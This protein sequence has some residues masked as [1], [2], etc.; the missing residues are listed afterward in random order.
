MFI[1]KIIVCLISTIPT[2]CHWVLQIKIKIINKR[3][4]QINGLL[5]K[6]TYICPFQI[7]FLS[8]L[9]FVYSYTTGPSMSLCM[10]SLCAPT[11]RWQVHTQAR[12]YHKSFSWILISFSPCLKASI[13][14]RT[15]RTEVMLLTTNMT[16]V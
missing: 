7:I 6:Q 12:G 4:S 14:T 11:S 13:N 15:H 2:E 1:I 3:F 5:T 16:V 9:I 8:C 10:L